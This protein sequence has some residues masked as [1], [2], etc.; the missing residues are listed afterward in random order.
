MKPHHVQNHIRVNSTWRIS[1]SLNSC[2]Y[3]CSLLLPLQDGGTALFV[4]S[5]NGHSA[6]VKQLLEAK[7]NRCDILV[8]HANVLRLMWASDK[9]GEYVRTLCPSPPHIRAALSAYP[10]KGDHRPTTH[11]GLIDS[12][13][14]VHL[15]LERKLSS[16]THPSKRLSEIY[17]QSIQLCPH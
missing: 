12:I 17:C 3:M 11:T 9:R 5:Q 2:T 7:A 6:V 8:V 15:P 13:A 1:L 10:S 4:A 14:Y 16:P